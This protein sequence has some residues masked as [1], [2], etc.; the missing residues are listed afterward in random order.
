MTPLDEA[1]GIAGSITALSKAMGF[2]YPSTVSNWKQAGGKVPPDQSPAIERIT[3][4]LCERLSP[5][6]EFIRGD[7]GVVTGY[8]TKVPAA[9]DKAA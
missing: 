4:V 1:I 9:S 3:G 5:D 6:F 8:I 2:P 7:D